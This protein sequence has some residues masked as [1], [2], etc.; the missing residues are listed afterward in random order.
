MSVEDKLGSRIIVKKV[1]PEIAIEEVMADL[2]VINLK[3]LMP[4]DV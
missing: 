3:N 2:F 4:R 1:H